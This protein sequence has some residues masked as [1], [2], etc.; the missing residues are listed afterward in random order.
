MTRPRGPSPAQRAILEALAQE[1]RYARFDE[2]LTLWIYGADDLVVRYVPAMTEEAL[3][4]RG[5]IERAEMAPDARW[6]ARRF[7][8]SATGRHALEGR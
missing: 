2:Y 8:I 6:P 3:R 5:W 4:R 7:R 1:G